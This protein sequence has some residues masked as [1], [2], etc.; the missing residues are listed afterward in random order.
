[1]TPQFDPNFDAGAATA[2]LFAWYQA[3]RRSYPWRQLFASTADPYV[4][5]ISEIML[6]QT[7]IKAVLP[8]YERFLQRFP[9][10]YT[11]A[12]AS[13][14]E[15]RMAVRGLGYYRRFAMLHAAAKQLAVHKPIRWP[16]TATAWKEL[17]GIGDYTAA[18]IA[19]IAFA[20]PVAVLDGNVERVLARLTDWRAPAGQ[21]AYKRAFRELAQQLIET[22]APGDSNQALMELGQTCCTPT[23]P[24]CTE[25]PLAAGCLSRQRGSVALAPAPKIRKAAEDINLQ[26]HIVHNASGQIGLL[27]RPATARFLKGTRGFPTVIGQD[28]GAGYLDGM[29]MLCA[30][31]GSV[32]GAIRHSITHHRITATVVDSSVTSWSRNY[33]WHWVGPEKIEEA[34]VSNLDRKAWHLWC[35]KRSKLISKK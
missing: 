16:R 31:S 28:A 13:E 29:D 25:C 5:W 32:C 19:S 33:P 26:L 20:E 3:N 12:A 9:D 2:A 23:N 11:L 30:K 10:I 14:D 6:Q 21:P 35:K 7:V 1:M 34:L 27:D 4:V 15:V 24:S 17:P 18:A 8:V 22:S